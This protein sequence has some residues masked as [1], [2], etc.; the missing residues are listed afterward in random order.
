MKL[1][2]KRAII[3]R[4]SNRCTPISKIVALAPKYFFDMGEIQTPRCNAKIIKILHYT[5]F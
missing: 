3:N 1:K 2:I 4:P 5:K